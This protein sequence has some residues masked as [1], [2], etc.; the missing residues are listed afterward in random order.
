MTSPKMDRRKKYTRMVL[1]ESLMELLKEKP[2]AAITV[3][4]ICEGADVNRSTFY[5]HYADQY[6]LLEQIEKELMED[7]NDNLNSFDFN[8]ETEALQVT[9]KLL[10]Y[11]A[12]N[13]DT[14]QILFSEH[15]DSAILTRVMGL[16]HEYT[17]K[18]IV[19][20]NQHIDEKTS[21]YASIFAIHGS[22]HLIEN[23]LNSGLKESPQE[24]AAIILK[25]TNTGISSF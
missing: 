17:V 20:S 25:L 9:E 21:E 8:V 12:E 1:K 18:N 13:K 7:L 16:A 22:V 24:I 11:V 6:A 5:S 14:C 15:V 19:A 4:E 2:V 23:W 3:K 10:E